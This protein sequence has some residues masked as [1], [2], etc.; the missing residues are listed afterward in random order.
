[1]NMKNTLIGALLISAP[2]LTIAQ[3]AKVQTAWRNISDYESSK[4]PS[5]LAKAKEAIDLAIVNED[6]KGKAKTWVY[7]AKVE[8]YSF[9][10]NLKNEETKLTA[11]VP[12]KDERKALA[13]GNVSIAEY[14]EAGKALQK[15]AELDKDKAYETDMGML[16]M[17]MMNDVN[18]LA[19]GRYKSKKYDEAADFYFTSFTMTKM[20]GKKDTSSLFNAILSSQ[21][22]GNQENVKKYAETMIREK[23]ADPYAYNVLYDAKMALKDSVGAMETLQAGRKA[24]PGSTDLMNKETEFYLRQ[25]KQDQALANLNLSIEKDPK[26]SLFYL[27]RGNVYDN[28]ANPK[29]EKGK[30]K[31]KPKEFEEYMTKAAAD[32][33]MASELDS[34][35]F[36]TWY[37]MGALYN[38]WGGYYDNKAN[39]ITKMNA[40]QKALADKAAVQFKNA[41]PALEKALDLKPT[42]RSTMQA[43]R[44]LYLITGETAKATAMTERMKK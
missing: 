3:S 29:D 33:K 38:N 28:L 35:S 37:N 15:A 12:D 25:G 11:T 16:G 20:M 30:D 27:V 36:D 2:L 19:F 40:E 18:N 24:F 44:K 7:K 39:A 22:S 34:K 5:S 13:Y 6:T 4:D 43:L 26:N 17:L 14:E 32:Y 23:M 8:Y 9:V 31:D 21:K 42:D 1:M 41:I 10:Q